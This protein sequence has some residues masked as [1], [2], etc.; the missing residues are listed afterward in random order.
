MSSRPKPVLHIQVP[1][2]WA[3]L[4]ADS[5]RG[6]GFGHLRMR[7]FIL[8]GGVLWNALIAWDTLT[9][10]VRG[11]TGTKQGMSFS[12]ECEGQPEIN[13]FY[14]ALGIWGHLLPKH[15]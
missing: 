11:E 15:I 14:S 7:A 10:S 3:P 5:M 8:W 9:V 2:D 6:G 12:S 4:V 1:L 13:L